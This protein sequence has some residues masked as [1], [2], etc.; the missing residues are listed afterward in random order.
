M[1]ASKPITV[2][3]GKQQASLD[4]HLAGG[5]YESASEVLRAGLR[6]LDREQKALDDLMRAKIQQALDDP[7]PAVPAEDVFRRLRKHMAERVEAEKRL[8]AE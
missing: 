6:A 1:R 5:N 7:R 3:L 8:A 2:T 4:A